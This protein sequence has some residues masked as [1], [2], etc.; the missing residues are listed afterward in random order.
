MIRFWSI[1]SFLLC[2][3]HSAF[4]HQEKSAITQ[5]LLNNR[6]GYLEVAHRFYIHDAEHAAKLITGKPADIFNSEDTQKA[7][8]EHVVSNFSLRIND[9]SLQLKN[10]GFELEGLFFWAY[11]EIAFDPAFLSN[12]FIEVQHSSLQ[13][14]WPDQ[15]NTVNLESGKGKVTTAIFQAGSEPSRL[16][17]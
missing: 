16:E 17:F 9:Q 11:Q 15:V 7:F 2:V 6:N 4:S 12:S 13:K 5:I 8:Y 3:S 1:V 10:I 14:F